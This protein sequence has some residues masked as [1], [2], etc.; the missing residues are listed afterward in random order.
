M[1]PRWVR[2]RHGFLSLPLLVR[3]GAM[4]PMG[5]RNDRPDYDYA[6]GVTIRTYGLP[7]GQSVEALVPGLDGATVVT[8][9][10]HRDG[11]RAA[12]EAVGATGRW[13]VLLVG[14]AGASCIEGGT[15]SR[16]DAGTL[17]AADPGAARIIV[18]LDSR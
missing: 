5:C 4:L 1:G 13:R 18:E 9:T 15:A 8:V 16:A 2:E 10:G 7:D 6:D 14:E 12:F 17:I 3:P 11:R